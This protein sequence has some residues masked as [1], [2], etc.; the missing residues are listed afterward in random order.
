M[1]L[2]TADK[3]SIWL[4]NH[5]NRVISKQGLANMKFANPC[6]T[7]RVILNFHCHMVDLLRKIVCNGNFIFGKT[8]NIKLTIEVPPKMFPDKNIHHGCAYSFSN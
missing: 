5:T 8:I 2:G 3:G 4:R 6:R 7:A 1:N